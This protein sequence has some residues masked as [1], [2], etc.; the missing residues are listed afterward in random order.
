MSR[1]AELDR[2]VLTAALDLR[3]PLAF[4]ALGP[5]LAFGRERGIEINWLP[6]RAQLLQPPSEP[7]STDDRGTRHRR[8]RAYM[9]QRE[10]F[11]YAEAQG[12]VVREPYRAGS[13]DA[14]HGAWLWMRE[15]NASALEGFLEDLFRRYWTL[16]LDP[17]DPTAL[18]SLVAEHRGDGDAYHAWW[19]AEGNAALDAV[20][21]DLISAGLSQAPSYLVEDEVFRGRQHLPMIAWILD[22]RDGPVPI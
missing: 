19:D 17:A 2:A 1:G 4:L 20:E 18:A 12:L 5:T 7:A 14:A 16:E 9:I 21:S 3:H 11:V 22:G 6:L 15:Q 10:I 8:H 13:T